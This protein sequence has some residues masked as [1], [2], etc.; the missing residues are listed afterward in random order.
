MQKKEEMSGALRHMRKSGALWIV[1]CAFV[2]GIIMLII[3]SGASKKNQEEEPY[4]EH[5]YNTESFETYKQTLASSITASCERLIGAENIYVLLDFESSGEII[6]AQNSNTSSDGDR[7]EEYVIVGSGSNA[8]ALY[9]GQKFPVL[10]GIGIICPSG[11]SQVKKDEISA[12]L[13]SAYGLPLTRI[14]VI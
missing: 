10:S 5:K 8:E 7:K 2:V 3:G 12:L 11:V 1:I 13:S 4:D 14:Y 6:Y 9:L